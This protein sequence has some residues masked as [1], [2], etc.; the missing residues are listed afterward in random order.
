[1]CINPVSPETQATNMHFKTTK[2]DPGSMDI[3]KTERLLYFD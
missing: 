1:M 3:T 2:S